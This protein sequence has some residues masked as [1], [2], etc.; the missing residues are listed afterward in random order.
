MNYRPLYILRA[1]HDFFQDGICRALRFRI[2]PEGADLWR[3]R[4]LLLRQLDVNEWAVLYDSDGA[5]VDTVSDAL[6]LEMDLEDPAFVLYTKWDGLRPDSAYT[7]DLPADGPDTAALFR[8]ASPKRKIGAGFCRVRIRLAGEL[9]EAAQKGEPMRFTMHFHAPECR[10]EYLVVPRAD[11]P[12]EGKYILEEGDGKL[13]FSPFK[14]V[15]M[16]GRDMLRSVSREAVPMRERYGYKLK[17]S[18]TTGDEGGRKQPV[19]KR[20]D[21]PEPGR[22]MDTE[23]GLC[24]Q[25]C[26]L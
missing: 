26:T 3:R 11:A 12:G 21:P 22:F 17:L 14:S 1:E 23:P 8:E 10:W 16:Y 20:V 5:G 9:V 15:R 25:V 7:L 2:S 24:R 18:L 6:L 13:H 4:A 19:L